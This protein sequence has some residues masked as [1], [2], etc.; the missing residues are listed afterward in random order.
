[1]A[2]GGVR[3]ER[4]ADGRIEGS[5]VLAPTADRPPE[6]VAVKAVTDYRPQVR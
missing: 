2:F 5:V 3:I 6:G 4:V 1:V